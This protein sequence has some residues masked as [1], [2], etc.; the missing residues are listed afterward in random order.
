MGSTPDI[1]IGSTATRCCRRPL[2]LHRA[3][4]NGVV[5][6]CRLGSVLGKSCA[7]C[8]G[9]AFFRVSIAPQFIGWVKDDAEFVAEQIETAQRERR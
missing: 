5:T 8:C 1:A 4:K 6:R 2:P 3:A 7:P 9:I